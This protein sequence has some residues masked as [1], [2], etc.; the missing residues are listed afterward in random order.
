MLLAH[1]FGQFFTNGFAQFVNS[2]PGVAGQSQAGKQDVFLIDQNAV[3]FIQVAGHFGVQVS[4]REFFVFAGDIFGNIGHGAGAEK[5]DHDHNVFQTVGFE[6]LE[7]FSHAA[8][9]KLKHPHG[10]AAGEHGKSD[11]VIHG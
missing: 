1:L 6:F 9:A 3:R 4:N 11:W 7:P 10:F 5:G 2:F 8:A